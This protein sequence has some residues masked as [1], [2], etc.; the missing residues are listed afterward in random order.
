MKNVSHIILIVGIGIAAQLFAVLNL[1][2]QIHT[3]LCEIADKMP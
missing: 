3:V 1:L 2:V